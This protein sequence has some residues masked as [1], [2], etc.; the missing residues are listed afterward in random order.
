MRNKKKIILII[1]ILFV[2]G[3][4]LSSYK[5]LNWYIDNKTNRKIIDDLSDLIKIDKQ[6]NK[7]DVDFK[8]LKSKNS[9]TIAYL[10]VNNTNINYP[11]LK[12]TDNNYYLDHNFDKNYNIA[13]WIF[14]NYENKFNGSDKNIVI[15]GHNMRDGNMFGS[16]KNTLSSTWQEKKDNHEIILITENKIYTYQVFSTYEIENE[17]YYIKTNFNSD[18]EY[19]EFLNT[20]KNRSNYDY[21]ITINK[22]DKILT[23]STCANNNKYRVVLHAKKIKEEE[24]ER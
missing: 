13:G 5:I 17:E 16:L 24:H 8:S 4:I 18:D 6:N 21:N 23:L 15:F 14:A 19:T 9:D 22:D 7:Y 1:K 11:V 3:I 12:H 2:L 20:I 10:I